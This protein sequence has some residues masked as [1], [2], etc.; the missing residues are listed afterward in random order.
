MT[1]ID[2]STE[3]RRLLDIGQRAERADADGMANVGY[4]AGQRYWDK[5]R[6]C[7]NQMVPLI[8]YAKTHCNE[9]ESLTVITAARFVARILGK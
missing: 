7:A 8:E 4:P 2:P 1:D 9:S 3:L 5:A 6:E